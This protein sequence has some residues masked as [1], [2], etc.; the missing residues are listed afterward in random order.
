MAVK[1]TVVVGSGISGLTIALLQAQQGHEVT[2]VEK[3][4]F[5][6][7][8]INRYERNGL[9]LDIGFHFTGGANS[10]MPQILERQVE[11]AVA[12]AET[13]QDVRRRD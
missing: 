9:R 6:G 4:P 13:Q 12:R 1:R 5:I 8:Y 3:L 2:L 7:G 10:L 11:L